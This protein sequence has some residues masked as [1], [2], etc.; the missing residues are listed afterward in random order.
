[1]WAIIIRRFCDRSRRVA[2]P[3]PVRME[4]KRERQ[5]RKREGE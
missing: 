2:P 5:V 3:R 1:L 4:R